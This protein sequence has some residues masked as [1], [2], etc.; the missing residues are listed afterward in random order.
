MRRVL[1]LLLLC[2]LYTSANAQ[3]FSASKTCSKGQTHR[4]ALAKTTVADPAEDDYDMQYVKMNLSATNASVALSGDVT[5]ISKVIAPSLSSYVFE[6]DSLYT[7]DSILI[8]NVSMPFTTDS[9]VRKVTLNP[10]LPQNSIFTAQ[11]FYHGAIVSGTA[12]Y[13]TGIRRQQS[14]S[15]GNFVTYTMSEPYES[16]D[17]WP[18]KQSLT[19]KLDSADMWI[20]VP[21]NLKAG[22]N[23]VLQ[24]VTPM[25]NSLSRYEWKTRYPID[26]YLLSFSAA[27]YV[28]YSYYIHFNNSTD[29]MLVQNYV[30]D[31]PLTLPF[32]QSQIDS[33]G[34][35]IQYLSD[36]FGRYPFWQ[37]KYG[38][39]MAPLSGGMEHQ[40]MTT[41]GNFSTTLS[42][43]ELGHQWFGDHVTCQTWKDIW[44]NEGFASYVEYLYVDHFYG[45]G[46]AFNYMLNKHNDVMFFPAGSVYVDDTT[47]ESRIF[48]DR[49]TYKKGASIVH[50]LRFVF[51]NDTLFFNALKSYQSQY[52]GKTATTEDMKHVCEQTLGQNLDTFFNQWIYKEGYPIYGAT[53]NQ[54]GNQ[55]WVKLD[56]T[57]SDPSVTLF[58]TPLELHL[59]STLGDTIVRV[60]NNQQSQ[61]FSFTW[62]QPMSNLFIDP[63]DWI[64]NGDGAIFQDVCLNIAGQAL[65]DLRIYPNPTSKSWYVTNLG[66]HSM[67]QLTDI[68]GRVLWSGEAEN[69]TT[70]PADNLS[71]GIYL[72]KIN[73]GKLTTTAKL[74]KQ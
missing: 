66:G 16:R 28:D 33:V 32:F 44:L 70:I 20:T 14:P 68:S 61:I 2:S 69:N 18:C 58:K 35:M 50:A 26:Y 64:L 73:N 51:N 17:W 22:S 45:P 10:A 3:D 12:F 59:T 11:V 23:G 24:A 42:V 53:W 19:D 38:H 6:L 29:S 4:N 60:Y 37:E 56:Q 43:H 54:A 46:D 71:G 5:T 63:N 62:N 13:S 55:V 25:P 21:S 74:I 48:S 27:S 39:C 15:W 40:T 72:L 52:A 49:L 30:Y 1:S 34:L 36:L 31:N 65:P 9:F 7:I 8:N 41:L 47:D 67:L 57:T